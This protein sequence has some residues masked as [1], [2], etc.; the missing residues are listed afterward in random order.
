M[1]NQGYMLEGLR[2]QVEE[3]KFTSMGF[4]NGR[5]CTEPR[6]DYRYSF[7]LYSGTHLIM[8]SNKQ[9]ALEKNA[10]KAAKRLAKKHGWKFTKKLK[11][12]KT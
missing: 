10:R 1:S 9:W 3:L 4:N 8:K 11:K 6:V 12:V 5:Q 7:V 2:I